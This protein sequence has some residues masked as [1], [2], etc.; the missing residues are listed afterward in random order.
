[1]TTKLDAARALVALLE[2]APAWLPPVPVWETRDPDKGETSAL[3]GGLDDVPDW[4]DRLDRLA[5]ATGSE[6]TRRVTPVTDYVS[7]RQVVTYRVRWWWCGIEAQVWI[8]RT[9]DTQAAPGVTR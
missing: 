1:M 7:G 2:Q 6:V 5:D 4:R 8:C 9:E 3:L